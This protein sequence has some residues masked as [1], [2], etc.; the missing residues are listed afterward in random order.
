MAID[1]GSLVVDDTASSTLLEMLKLFVAG[2]GWMDE[3]PND[4]AFCDCAQLMG[5]RLD[6]LSAAEAIDLIE[7]ARERGA[8][9]V[10]CSHEIR[11]SEGLSTHP[12]TL[13]AIC[14]YA[15][16]PDKGL[17]LDTVETIA[18]YV[19]AEQAGD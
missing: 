19:Q 12:A 10:F 15:G 17:W 16:D 2:R 9:L 3:G 18:R 5:M 4:P 7:A 8:W 14:A 13:D 6:G 11:E 1:W